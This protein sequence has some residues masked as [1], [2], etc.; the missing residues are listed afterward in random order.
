MPKGTLVRTIH[1]LPFPWDLFAEYGITVP[2]G[3]LGIIIGKGTIRTPRGTL[4]TFYRVLLEGH[5]QD[6]WP[7]EVNP[8]CT[9]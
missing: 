9:E 2:P 1:Y 4:R 8:V 3:T 5:V 7:S 6:M